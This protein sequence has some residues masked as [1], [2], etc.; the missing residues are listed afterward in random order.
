MNTQDQIKLSL[1]KRHKQEKIFR[2]AGI[3]SISLSLLFLVILFS[4]IISKG[5]NSF[6][7]HKIALD[8][9][10]KEQYFEQNVS[11]RGIIKEILQKNLITLT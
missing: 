9:T 2:A 11:H 5:Y 1:K 3:V 4:S 6:F 7:K 8:F 10:I